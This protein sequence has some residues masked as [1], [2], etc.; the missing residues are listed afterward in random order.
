MIIFRWEM[1]YFSYFWS[2]HRLW[3][4]IRTTSLSWGGSNVYHQSVLSKNKYTPVKF[5]NPNFTLR[6]RGVRGF[7]LHGH[8]SMMKIMVIYM[9]IAR[10]RQP[11]NFYVNINF[12]SLWSFAES[13][14]NLKTFYLNS[15]PHINVKI[16]DQIWPCHKMG[17]GQSMVIILIKYDGP[18]APMLHTSFH[19]C[20]PRAADNP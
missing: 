19:V 9:Y 2:K 16:R 15:L 12:V 10:G 11:Q 3:V 17:Q 6:N 20:N 14:S 1:W 13:F 5:V 18:K 7:S 4:H 8:V